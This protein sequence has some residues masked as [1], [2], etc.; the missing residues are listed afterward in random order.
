MRSFVDKQII[1][2]MNF[3]ILFFYVFIGCM[4]VENSFV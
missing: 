4:D 3:E 2:A 1:H